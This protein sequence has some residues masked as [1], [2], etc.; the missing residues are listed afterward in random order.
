VMLRVVEVIDDGTP[1]PP[2]ADETICQ[3]IHSH[4]NF[5]GIPITRRPNRVQSQIGRRTQA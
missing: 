4:T 3:G 5:A 2:T 1:H